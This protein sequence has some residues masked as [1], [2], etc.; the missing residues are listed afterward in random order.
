[1]RTYVGKGLRDN[2][3]YHATEEPPGGWHVRRGAPGWRRPGVAGQDGLD[4]LGGGDELGRLPAG[5]DLPDRAW[6]S[7]TNPVSMPQASAVADL[8]G[9]G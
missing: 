3:G 7:L 5:I 8:A 9:G 2:R 6:T 4:A 1:L